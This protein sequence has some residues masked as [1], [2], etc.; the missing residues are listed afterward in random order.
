MTEA[1]RDRLRGIPVFAH[2]GH[3][4]AEDFEDSGLPENPVPVVAEWIL[5]A[6]AAGQPEPHAMSLCTV[7]A[8]GIPSSRVLLVKDV[9]ADRLFFAT[10]ADS[11][12]GTDIAS[13]PHVAAHFYWPV[14]G[15]QVRITGTASAQDRDASERDFAE[16][17]RGSRLSAHLH[18]PGPLPDRRTALEEFRRLDALHP[19]RV[20]CPPS[21]TLYA[22][23]PT[24]VEFWEA[25]TDRVH[26]RV[27]YR[28]D[29]AGD[30]WRHE[31]LWP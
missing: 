17:G 10:P 21:W 8:Q 20:P 15:R 24:E 29:T 25:G 30:A 26:H 1:I 13:N 11:R 5:A 23:T 12:K 14:T 18:R 16:R 7:D 22:I 3:V 27:R 2:A 31:L 6:H 28:R 9:D 4:G 19:D